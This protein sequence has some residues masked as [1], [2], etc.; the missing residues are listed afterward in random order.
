[1]DIMGPNTISQVSAT[2]RRGA[3]RQLAKYLRKN[4]YLDLPTYMI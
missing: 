2:K 4:N 1:M 3:E